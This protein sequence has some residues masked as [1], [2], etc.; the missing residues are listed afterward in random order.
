MLSL[1]ISKL[2]GINKWKKLEKKSQKNDLDP[3]KLFDTGNTIL[4]R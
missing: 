3:P 2:E 4:T 1:K